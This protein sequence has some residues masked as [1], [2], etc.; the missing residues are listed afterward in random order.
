VWLIV[1]QTVVSN[2]IL[3]RV[4]GAGAWGAISDP[5]FYVDQPIVVPGS[6]PPEKR[7]AVTFYFTP[8]RRIP[9]PAIHQGTERYPSRCKG[10]RVFDWAPSSKDARELDVP[11]RN[12]PEP[13]PPKVW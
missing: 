4:L 9:R 8:T 3:D 5:V 2:R 10:A 1:G 12:A 13:K 11:P 6:N 7:G